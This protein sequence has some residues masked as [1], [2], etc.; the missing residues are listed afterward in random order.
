[1]TSSLLML[2][3]FGYHSIAIDSNFTYYEFSN[4]GSCLT[5]NFTMTKFHMRNLVFP[6]KRNLEWRIDVHCG[7]ALQRYMQNNLCIDSV[8]DNKLA[9][10]NELENFL[11]NI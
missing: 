2:E 4:S 9:V 5:Q 11:P 3:A 7:G 10:V 6:W 8:I 1:M